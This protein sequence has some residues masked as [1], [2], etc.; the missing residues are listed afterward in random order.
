M[1]ESALTRVLQQA[2][3]DWPD[4]ALCVGFSGGPDSSALLHALAASPQARARGLRAVH[5]DHGLNSDSHQWAAQCQAFCTRIDVPLEVRRVHVD[6]QSGMGPEA[7]ARAA[8]YAAFAAV[9][10][11]DESLLT[12]HHRDDQAETVLLKLLRGAGPEGLGGMRERRPFAGGWLW[13]PLLDTPREVLAD[14]LRDHAIDSIQDPSNRSPQYARNFLRLDILPRLAAHWSKATQAI[15]H[16]A[17]LSRQNADCIRLRS[18]ETLTMLQRPDDHSLDAPGWLDLHPALHAPVLEQWL[19]AQ[20]LNAPTLGQR[21]QLLRQIRDAAAD[22]VPQVQWPGT[23]VHIWRGRLYAH[24]PLPEV[25]PGWTRTWHGEVLELP[26]AGGTLQL[27]DT[28]APSDTPVPALEVR[29]GETGIHFRP[30]GDGHTR[31]LRDL[32]QQAG[33]PPWR[34][35]RMPLIY[36]TD[37]RLLAV[38]DQWQ[39]EAGK[40]LFEKLEKQPKI[41]ATT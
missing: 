10:Q 21:E 30:A 29:L 20:G 37:G 23:A 26:G 9:L 17:R 40:D 4:G 15:N 2:L 22:R 34:R 3:D 1:T 19:H 8:R 14:Y 7:A 41:I 39:T 25:P 12:A 32:Y 16:S 5:V 11:P 38:A 6:E 27:V 24:P 36:S 28:G 33:I 35:R 13:R 18:R 31:E